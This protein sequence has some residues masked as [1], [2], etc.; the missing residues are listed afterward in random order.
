M[1]VAFLG[2]TASISKVIEVLKSSTYIG[3]VEDQEHVLRFVVADS[4]V[5]EPILVSLR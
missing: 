3:L 5:E 1:I 4:A 2:K